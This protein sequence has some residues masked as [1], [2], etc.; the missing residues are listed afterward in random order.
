M[1]L[2]LWKSIMS[3]CVI[4][5]AALVAQLWSY[6]APDSNIH[7]ELQSIYLMMIA[8]ILIRKGGGKWT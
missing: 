3:I 5:G 2:P 1:N 6:T 4:V 8:I 7:D